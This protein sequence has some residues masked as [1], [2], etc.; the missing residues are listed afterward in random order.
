MQCSATRL[1][2]DCTFP[3]HTKQVSYRQ[4]AQADLPLVSV[5]HWV[6]LGTSLLVLW[7]AP[8]EKL[9]LQIDYGLPS[10]ISDLQIWTCLWVDWGLGSVCQWDGNGPLSR[11]R[12]H[13]VQL[14]SKRETESLKPSKKVLC[15]YCQMPLGPEHTLCH[16]IAQHDCQVWLWLYTLVHTCI[17][18]RWQKS[19]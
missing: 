14:W 8:E 16:V 5:Q 13:W 2:S 15:V 1:C 18:R 9:M 7:C 17:T 19:Q 3:G 6:A 11:V 10:L 12:L 4:C